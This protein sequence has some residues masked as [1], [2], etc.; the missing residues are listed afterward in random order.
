[1]FDPAVFSDTRIVSDSIQ[2]PFDVILERIILNPFFQ[3]MR[4][5]KVMRS[6]K[7]VFALFMLKLVFDSYHDNEEPSNNRPKKISK[8]LRQEDFSVNIEAEWNE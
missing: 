8:D 4:E 7:F 2:M 5:S 1:M 3:S 6:L